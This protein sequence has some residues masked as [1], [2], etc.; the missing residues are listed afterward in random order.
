MSLSLPGSANCRVEIHPV[1]LYSIADVYV[2]REEGK[3]RVIGTLLGH[4]TPDGVVHVEECYAG[5]F[6]MSPVLP[7]LRIPRY[8]VAPG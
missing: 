4:T 5:N 7:R 2:R 8:P 3:P 6:P 1:V